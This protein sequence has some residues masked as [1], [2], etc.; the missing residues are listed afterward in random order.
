[1]NPTAPQQPTMTPQTMTK[2]KIFNI[3]S[4][5]SQKLNGAKNSNIIATL[6]SIINKSNDDVKN[7][8]F[9]VLHAEI[10]NSFYLVNNA[11]NTIIVNSIT[12]IIQNGNYNANSLGVAIKNA[13]PVGFSI[14]YNTNILKYTMTYSSSFTISKKS[15]LAKIVGLDTLN[16]S[17]SIGISLTFP[18]V[19]NFLP[20][21]RINFRSPQLSFGNYN[22]ADNSHDMFLSVQNSGSLGTM[23]LYTNYTFLRYVYEDENLITLPIRITDDTNTEID[24]NGVDWYLCFQ[25]DIEYTPVV[26][27][28]TFSKIVG[29]TL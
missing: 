17:N 6:P 5:N 12:Y 22:Q 7:I 19:V 3:S 10:P 20:V 13:L 1:M 4:A 15:T 18:Y 9:S 26:K 27:T 29:S 23:I 14:T 2:S 24:F 16:D 25:L 11:N 21:P 28:S 8:Y